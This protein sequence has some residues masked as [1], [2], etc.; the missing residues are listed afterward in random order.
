MC[1]TLCTDSTTVLPVLHRTVL[2]LFVQLLFFWFLNVLHQ[3]TTLM[4]RVSFLHADNSHVESLVLGVSSHNESVLSNSHKE[5]SSMPE[6]T[7]SYCMCQIV[8]TYRLCNQTVCQ[9]MLC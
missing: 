7:V 2:L 6:S 1:L 5:S 3:S 8:Y 9:V 4:K